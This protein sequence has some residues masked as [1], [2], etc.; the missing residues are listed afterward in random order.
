MTLDR[1]PEIGT[2]ISGTLKTIHLVEAFTAEL[3][4]LRGPTPLTT[5]A[6]KWIEHGDDEDLENPGQGEDLLDELYVALD[7]LAPEGAYFGS[8]PGDGADFGFWP[9]EDW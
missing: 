3:E 7:E 6:H 9:V 4:W 5:K 2:V 1:A 8:L